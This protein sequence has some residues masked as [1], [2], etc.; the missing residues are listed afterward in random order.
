MGEDSLCGEDIPS[1]ADNTPRAANLEYPFTP[2]GAQ[3]AGNALLAL[4]EAQPVRTSAGIK[5]GP[6]RSQ[7]DTKGGGGVLILF[8]RGSFFHPSGFHLD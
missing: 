6:N 2:A 4:E 8:T 5:A 1:L 7:S 3:W